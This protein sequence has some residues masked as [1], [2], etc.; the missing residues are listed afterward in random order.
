MVKR[1]DQICCKRNKNGNSR[2]SAH[3][4]DS[5]SAW[6]WQ[7]GFAAGSTL[8]ATSDV[9][10]TLASAHRYP[11]PQTTPTAGCQTDAGWEVWERTAGV[12]LWPG[13][14]KSVKRRRVH[15]WLLPAYKMAKL[16]SESF[17]VMLGKCF[18]IREI[19]KYMEHLKSCECGKPLAILH[20][21]NFL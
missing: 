20:T 11:G 17:D 4:L 12:P 6:Q 19:M 18:C 21:L 15:H 2:L 9:L 7:T 16:L 5:G 1:T 10:M 14:L 13:H 8:S 3:L